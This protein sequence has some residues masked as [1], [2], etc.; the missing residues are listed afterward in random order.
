[1]T[2]PQVVVCAGE[3]KNPRKNMPIALI[4]TV[5][6]ITVFYTVFATAMAGLLPRC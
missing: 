2:A 3:I 4:L 1:M 6:I 5:V